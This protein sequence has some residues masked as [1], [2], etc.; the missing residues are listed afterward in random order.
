MNPVKGLVGYLL[1]LI[2][3]IVTAVRIV[4]VFS[5]TQDGFWTSGAWELMMVVLMAVSL[6]Y[7]L[8]TGFIDRAPMPATQPGFQDPAV[9]RY[10]F[11]N[12]Q[13]ATFWTMIRFYVGFEWFS[14]GYVKIIGGEGDWMTHGTALKGFWTFTLAQNH[15]GANAALAYDWWYNFLDYMNKNEWYTWFAKLIAL[16]EF[17][18]GIAMLLGVLVGIAAFFG[19]VLNFSYMLTGVA[20]VNPLMFFLTVLLVV[21][22]KVA[23]LFGADRYL[24]PFLGTPWQPGIILTQQTPS[25]PARVA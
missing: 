4:V 6:V 16:G 11:N 5:G 23:G 3:V 18:V 12:P 14:A 19:G 13:T 10:L 17:A 24:L 9:V 21:A 22:W 15:G 20:G 1:L 8:A 7:V 2:G 25:R